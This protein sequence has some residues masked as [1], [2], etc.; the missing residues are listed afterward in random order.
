MPAAAVVA[1]A[2]ELARV[3][4]LRHRSGMEGDPLA[5]ILTLASARCVRIGTLRAGGT[6]ALR[7]PSSPED[8]AD[9]GREGRLLARR[10][11]RACARPS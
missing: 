6:W 9:R 1:A 5:D 4:L 7:F 10:R 2:G 3:E 11:R 8:Q